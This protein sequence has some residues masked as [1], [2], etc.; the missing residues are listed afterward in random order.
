MYL[1][2][3]M[4]DIVDR[5]VFRLRPVGY[6]ATCSPAA[7]VYSCMPSMLCQGADRQVIPLYGI[8]PQNQGPPEMRNFEGFARWI[9]AVGV[10]EMRGNARRVRGERALTLSHSLDANVTSLSRRGRGD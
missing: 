1:R 2:H 5:S 7:S 4:L 6:G 8:V 9:R 10:R 3:L